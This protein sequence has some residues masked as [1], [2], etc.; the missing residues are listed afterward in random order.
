MFR[1]KVVIYKTGPDGKVYRI[2][3]EFTDP[4]EY[5]RFVASN[6]E[7]NFDFS[8]RLSLGEWANL[9]RWIEDLI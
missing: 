3:K 4:K 7:L 9:E 8:P 5:E 2:E 6:P 1:G